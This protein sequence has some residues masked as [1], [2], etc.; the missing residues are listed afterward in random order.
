[1]TKLVIIIEQE[2]LTSILSHGELLQYFFSPFVHVKRIIG[3]IKQIQNKKWGNGT[4]HYVV[5]LKDMSIHILDAQ[6]SPC[7]LQ[8]LELKQAERCVAFSTVVASIKHGR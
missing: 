8:L 1:M 3:R 5:L 6:E 4:D 7:S 2:A